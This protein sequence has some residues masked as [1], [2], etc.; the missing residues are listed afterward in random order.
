MGH[1][2]PGQRIAQSAHHGLLTDNRIE[3]LGTP[4][5]GENKVGHFQPSETSP[6][7]REKRKIE[8]QMRKQG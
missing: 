2:V 5:S 6:G 8:L 4:F 1:P 3:I 7:K